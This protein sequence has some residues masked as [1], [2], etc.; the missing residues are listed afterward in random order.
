MNFI[1]STVASY[2]W[3]VVCWLAGTNLAKSTFLNFAQA[4]AERTDNSVDDILINKLRLHIC[5]MDEQGK[6]LVSPDEVALLLIEAQALYLL[7]IKENTIYAKH[8]LEKRIEKKYKRTKFILLNLADID[9]IKDFSSSLETKIIQILN[10]K[11]IDAGYL[12]NNEEANFIN[13]IYNPIELKIN[14]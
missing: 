10:E 6:S 4:L 5:G 3:S 1:Y 13:W 2:G 7:S 11:V 12:M 8:L 9:D 14:K